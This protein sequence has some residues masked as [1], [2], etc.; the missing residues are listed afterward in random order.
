MP[1]EFFSTL[2]DVFSKVVSNISCALSTV[3]ILSANSSDS[4]VYF[5]NDLFNCSYFLASKSE[6]CLSLSIFANSLL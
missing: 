5:F 6:E 1:D 2:L 3:S 4:F